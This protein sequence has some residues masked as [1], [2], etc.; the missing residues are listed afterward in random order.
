MRVT[1]ELPLRERKCL[2]TLKALHC[3]AAGLALD[4]GMDKV[5]VDAIASR[6]N[7]STR[8]FFNYFASKEDAILG[9]Q[10]P[11]M[12]EEMVAEFRAATDQDL[13]AR[14]ARL[15][16]RVAMSSVVADSAH[17]REKLLKRFPELAPRQT[18]HVM[19]IEELVRGVVT[20]HIAECP[21]WAAPR[22]QR[23]AAD[24]AMAIVMLAGASMRMAVRQGITTKTPEQ[25]LVTIDDAVSLL[26]E[27]TRNLL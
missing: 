11:H 22:K 10:E 20:E 2:E 7:V 1:N 16:F 12:D 27:V 6:A 5:T 8:T 23:D 14:V 3:E 9:I 18:P 21:E 17:R 4:D 15:I 26:R 24:I 25:Q 13:L 19:R